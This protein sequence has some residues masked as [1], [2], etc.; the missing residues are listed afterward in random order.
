[1][2]SFCP[3]PQHPENLKTPSPPSW[4]PHQCHFL[5]LYPLCPNRQ[6]PKNILHLVTLPRPIFIFSAD[7][8]LRQS[9]YLQR[10]TWS[11]TRNHF[12]LP[13][14]LTLKLFLTHPL[15]LGLATSYSLCLPWS[16]NSGLP[17]SDLPFRSQLTW[18]FLQKDFP[19]LSPSYEIRYSLC[20]AMVPCTV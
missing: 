20:V 6:T 17:N 11:V 8:N 13:E 3:L 12:Q 2:L 4:R 5:L 7:S 18:N 14:C 9:D 15:G 16:P 19:D 1:M 10:S